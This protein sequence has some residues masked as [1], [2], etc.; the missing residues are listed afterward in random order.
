MPLTPNSFAWM[1]PLR[2]LPRSSNRKCPELNPAASASNCFLL[3]E[4][5]AQGQVHHPH[6]CV[7]D[8]D[9]PSPSSSHHLS[10]A[11][12][13][14]PIRSTFRCFSSPLISLSFYFTTMVQTTSPGEQRKPPCLSP[15]L[16]SAH[17]VSSVLPITAKL[18]L[19]HLLL[20]VQLLKLALNIKLLRALGN[21]ISTH[22][23]SHT[24][25]QFQLQTPTL[26]QVSSA[27]ACV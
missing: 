16:Q 17:S 5:L 4:L 23:M 9:S 24:S 3:L 13:S 20:K 27:R 2:Y 25:A 26:T 18:I 21:P 7:R 8:W 11:P 12:P 6:S 14:L 19:P 1:S 15:C 10:S 22:L